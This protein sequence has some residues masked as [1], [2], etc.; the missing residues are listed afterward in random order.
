MPCKK[1][2]DESHSDVPAQKPAQKPRNPPKKKKSVNPAESLSTLR[3]LKASA[4]A[5]YGG[6]KHTATNHNGSIKRGQTFL[7]KLVS[8]IETQRAQILNPE[9][10]PPT[11]N[12]SEEE[13]HQWDEDT[14]LE[15]LADA[16][17]TPNR[18]SVEAL[19]LFLT[20]KCCKEKRSKS[21]AEVIQEAFKKHWDEM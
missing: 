15:L 1:K 21:T 16:F 20:Q 2:S 4:R 9:L 7:A 19:E 10:Y 14:N 12:N 5:E 3:W 17:N 18:Y 13:E 6:S 11:T 8:D